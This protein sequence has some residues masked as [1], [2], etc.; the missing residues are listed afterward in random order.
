MVMRQGLVLAG[1]GLVVGV[2]LSLSVTKLM[3]G[4]LFNTPATDAGT[5]VLVALMLT[6]IAGMAC[7]LPA[8]RALK[9]DPVQALRAR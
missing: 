5:F 3:S 2:G 8:R 1:L 7:F 6:A 4:L 9:V